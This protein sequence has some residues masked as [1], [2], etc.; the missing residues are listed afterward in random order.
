MFLGNT[1]IKADTKDELLLIQQLFSKE[2]FRLARKKHKYLTK[3]KI[4]CR[5][6]SLCSKFSGDI[7]L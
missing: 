4:A 5:K 3:G 1:Y 2:K 6:K 7:D